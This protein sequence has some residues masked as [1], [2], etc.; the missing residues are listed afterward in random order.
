[1]SDSIV[2]EA[3]GVM[4]LTKFYAAERSKLFTT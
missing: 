3:H 1:M 4:S 2:F